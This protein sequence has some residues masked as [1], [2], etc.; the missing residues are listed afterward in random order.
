MLQS[1]TYYAVTQGKSAFA[2]EASKNLNAEQRVYYHLIAI[3]EYMRVAGI[4][5]E[6][7]FELNVK[8]VKSVIDKDIRLALNDDYFVFGL[9]N[10]RPLIRFVPLSAGM[11]TYKS[12]NPL[13]AIIKSKSGGYEVRYGNR[14]ATRITTDTFEYGT[15]PSQIKVSIDGSKKTVKIG[16]K[17]A[18]KNSFEFE[19]LPGYRLNVIGYNARGDEAGV[20]IEKSKFDK[21]YSI[22]KA[23]KIYRAEFYELGNGKKDKFAGMILVEF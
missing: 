1:L 2:N 4:E 18:V 10:L 11:P 20:L 7:P 22:D 14:L 23:G 19:K 15:K 3:E 6:R 5:F 13:V 8:S 12:D 17:I 9:K 21:N 16:E